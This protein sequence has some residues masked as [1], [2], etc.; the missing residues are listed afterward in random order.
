MQLITWKE[1]ESIE[2]RIGTIIAVED[3]PE[4]RK[5]AYKV[6]VDFWEDIG[7]KQSSAQ[8]TIHYTKESLI[9]TQILWVVNFPTK[10]VWPFLSEFLITWFADKDGNILLARPDGLVPN[11]SKLH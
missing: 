5:P 4:A 2:L 8:I 9:G 6:T 3:F 10:Q 7:I 1:F 11:G